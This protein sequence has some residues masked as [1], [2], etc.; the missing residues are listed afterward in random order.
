MQLLLLIIIFFIIYIIAEIGTIAFKLTGLSKDTARFQ[1]ISLITNTG[2]TTGEAELIVRDKTRRRI[3]AF[4]MVTFYVSLPLIIATVLDTFSRGL[5]ILNISLAIIALYIS[6]IIM[7]NEN[8]IAFLEKHIEKNLITYAVVQEK[9][10]QEI[11]AVDSDY[12]IVQV[13]IEN[14]DVVHKPLANLALQ[15]QE[16]I[17]LAIERTQELIKRPQGYHTMELGDK[18]LLYGD[19]NNIEKLFGCSEKNCNYMNMNQE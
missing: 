18:V 11:L 17:V 10:L 8:F 19:I 13:Y 4:L 7:R 5:T 12:K 2:F 14:H 6:Y 15:K 3:A 9:S 16:I 1:A